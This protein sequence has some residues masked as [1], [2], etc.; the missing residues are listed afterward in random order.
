MN[1][2]DIQKLVDILDE[3]R[4]KCPWDKKQTIH[5]LRQQT[6][7]E[8]YELT[9]AIDDENWPGIKEE[10]GDLLLHIVFY[11]KIGK[12]KN[13]FT[14]QDVIDGISEKLIRRHPH[15]YGDVVAND[16]ETVKKNWEKLKLAEGKK[17]I[18]SGVPSSLPA[19]VK[20]MRI[21]QKAAQTGFEWSTLSDV[22]EKVL[23][24]KQE[25]TEVIQKKNKEE[26]EKEAGDLLFSVVNYIRFCG[27]DAE[28]A[29]ELTNNKFIGR[30]KKME[31][32]VEAESHKKLTE[33]NLAEMDAVWERIKKNSSIVEDKR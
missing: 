33:L 13:E 22:W 17:S 6:I 7:E 31:E 29:L 20:A 1:N 2:T 18:M 25:L 19:L 3:L 32:M 11:S 27:V 4:I 28:Y 5:T 12:E 24:E 26:I 10:L 14:L 23:E 30:F 21:Q 16:A 9:D 8:L 15:V